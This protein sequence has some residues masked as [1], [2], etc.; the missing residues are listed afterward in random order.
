MKRLLL[1]LLL[2]PLYSRAQLNIITTIAGNG[3]AGYSGDNGPATNAQLNLTGDGLCRD[4]YGNIY[5]AEV[6]NHVIRKITAST[7][8]ITTIAGI[9]ISGYNGDNIPATNAQLYE[10]YD[11]IMDTAGNIYICDFLN[12]RVRKITAST[13][14]I[15]T[16]AGTGVAGYSGDNGPATNAQIR[17]PE[18]MCLDRLGNLYIAGYQSYNI[19]KVDTSGIITTFAGTTGGYS[20]DNGPATNA[21]I[22]A[23]NVSAD[24]LN[25]IYIADQFNSAIRRV[26]ATTGIITTIAGN[27]VAGYSGDNGP[28]T[29]ALLHFPTCIFIDSQQNIFISD[30]GNGAIRKINAITNIITAVAGNGTR[31]Y[32]G[33]N[34]P[35][36]NAELIGVGVFLDDTGSIYISDGLNNRIRKVYYCHGN[37]IASY[38]DTGSIVRGFTY[39][40]TTRL[41]DSVKWNFGD[42]GT[43]TLMN[44]VH[45]YT[46]NGTYH[47]CVTA[48][49]YC[50]SD[51]ACHDFIICSTSPVASF[52]DTG[53]LTVGYTYTGTTFM[54]DSVKWNFGD[55][56]TDTVLNPVH[57]F[58]ANG[59]YHVC[60]TVYTYCGSDSACKDVVVHGL[61]VNTINISK[62]EGIYPNPATNPLTISASDKITTIAITNLLGQ[63]IFTHEY[64]SEQVQVDIAN[65]PKGLYVIKVNGAEV[66]KFVKE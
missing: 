62:I 22:N 52:T 3:T 63:T 32:S 36:T 38:M 5:I 45:T 57:T 41:M 56:H 53:T 7:G 33:D 47:S 42:G 15:T 6:N 58:T 54:K 65:L 60:I 2:L 17:H 18:G 25:N 61:G 13:G 8:I 10:P 9:G 49:T 29:N 11:V 26:D 44:P 30:Q 24:S 19:R 51:S 50:G 37:P 39:T 64:N 59:T 43:S 28:A 4:K 12:N 16:I 35:A 21:Q 55:G 40:G 14:I 31:G 66:R 23:T 48:Y 46:A 1:I 20:G 27:G 34:G